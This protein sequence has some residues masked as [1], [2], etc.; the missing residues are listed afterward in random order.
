MSALVI[1]SAQATR[2]EARVVGNKARRLAELTRRGH[3]VP[4]FFVVASDVFAEVRRDPRVRDAERRLVAAASDGD[5]IS[6]EL[7]GLVEGATVPDAAWRAISDAY[8]RL[9]RGPV[10]VR[11][12]AIVEDDSAH[13]LAGQLETVLDV[14]DEEALRRAIRAVWA[15]TYGPRAVAYR[16]LR[17]M[18]ADS[19]DIAVIVQRFVPAD[20]SGVLFTVDPGDAAC[21]GIAAT[22][23]LGADLV[24][25]KV[26]GDTYEVDRVTF[27][28]ATRPAKGAPVLSVEE[29]R[30]LA[31]L[32]L[33]IERELGAPQDIEWAIAGGEVFVLQARPITATHARDR[34]RTIW[35]N[36]NIVESFP[37][38]TLPLTYSLARESYAA[39]YRQ[40]AEL[41][42][43]PARVLAAHDAAFQQM[44]G[45]IRG[46]VYYNL[47][48]W[49]E[50]LSLL[51]G[52]AHNKTFMEQMMGVRESVAWGA[53]ARFRLG[54]LDAAR[55]VLLVIRM[56]FL[57]LTIDR[58]AR[59]FE[60]MVETVCGE[61][62]RADL[63]RADVRELVDRY[64]DLARRIRLEW[65]A[66][67]LNDFLTMLYFGL[68]RRLATRWLLDGTG[69]L[70]NDL[71]RGGVE[72]RSVEPARRVAAIARL[73]RDD[74]RLVSLFDGHSD[75]E[76]ASLLA[77][78]R[79]PPVLE[80]PL[81]EY[82]ERF[83]HRFV[84][85]LKLEQPSL[86]DDAAPLFASIRPY[87]A[88]PDVDLASAAERDRAARRD[89][90]ARVRQRLA[91]PVHLPSPRLLFLRWVA[92]HARRHVRDRENMRFARG[93]VFGIARELFTGLGLRL[94]EAGHLDDA[95][96]VF[97]LTVEE[98]CGVQRGTSPTN[99]LR[100]LAALRQS[101]YDLYR[102]EAPLPD[103]FETRGLPSAEMARSLSHS[104]APTDG[105]LRGVPCCA[106]IARG[107]ANLVS[108]PRDSALR[109]GEI[110][111]ARETDPGWVTLFPLAAGILVER[112]SLLSHSAIVARELGVPTIVGVRGLTA[113]LR[114]GDVVEMD[115]ATGRIARLS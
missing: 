45:L 90:E 84:Q 63:R 109:A 83:G 42:G 36:S 65:K 82:L 25:G 49:Y 108:S 2:L 67:I 57:A 1:G 21:I 80:S 93:R 20:V 6:A 103:R 96:D 47:G 9:G 100:A 37:G 22:R 73:V 60:R 85:E 28:T 75:A 68:L 8:T 69:A 40:A 41:A 17:R 34:R 54:L 64:D 32:G 35:D 15:S 94:A 39:V 4:A 115:G 52:F 33:R 23:G 48:N 74:E 95:R 11:S 98:V 99:E 91:W 70:A 112:G 110:L 72:V 104:A 92:G 113:T 46:R 107:A 87:L 19:F 24:N 58:R 38:I 71:L 105:A 50:L 114:T 56:S 86:R 3:R 76:L 12:S 27:E 66:P 13:S 43:I 31:R 44:L 101:E 62:E 106:G 102:A 14:R 111:V 79:L 16:W 7:R 81:V 18:A 88:R 53:P 89:A 61:Y 30:S 77:A 10:A 51:P 55:L 59:A 5:A 29:T 78:G 97:Y 26:D